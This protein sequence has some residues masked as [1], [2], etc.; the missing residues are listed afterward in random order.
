[1]GTSNHGDVDMDW[2][3]QETLNQISKY[4][5]TSPSSSQALFILT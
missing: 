3:P 1:M 4:R 2:I 5:G